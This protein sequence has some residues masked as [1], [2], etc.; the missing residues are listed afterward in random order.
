[1]KIGIALHQNNRDAM[2]HENFGRCAWFGIYDSASGDMQ[3]IPNSDLDQ[4][5]H[6]GL[7]ASRLLAEEGVQVVVAG[8]FGSHAMDFLEKHKIRMV[9]TELPRRLEDIL[10]NIK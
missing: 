10:C 9:V 8:R 2:I 3:F 5:G 1:M 6:A 7:R 4:P